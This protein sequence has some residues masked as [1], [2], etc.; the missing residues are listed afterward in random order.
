MVLARKASV[1]LLA[2]LAALASAGCANEL[3]VAAK[4]RQAEA[5]APRIAIAR[6]GGTELAHGGSL[7]FGPVSVGGS[8]ELV[9]EVRNDGETTLVLPSGAISIAGGSGA[10]AAEDF[11]GLSLA[12]GKSGSFGLRFSPAAAGSYSATLTIA[13]NDGRVPAFA[14]GLT[15][16]GSATAKALT[17]FGIL[18][19][20]IL[21][22]IDEAAK[23][24]SLSLPPATV[25]SAL[26]PTFETTGARVLVG[27][28]VQTSGA[29]VQNFS[30]PVT[31]RV[32]AQDGST[33]DYVVTA[34]NTSI[35]PILGTVTLSS[36]T[37]NSAAG[38]SNVASSGDGEAEVAEC[39]LCWS[40]TA[41][42]TTANSKVVS[43]SK[44]GGF[45]DTVL[46]GLSAG[47]LYYVRAY[48]IND[49]GLTGYGAQSSFMTLPTQPTGISVS[50][51]GYAAGADRLTVSWSAVTGAS[52]Y[53][54]YASKNSTAPTAVT[55][56]TTGGVDV[57][58]TT[59]TLTG[60]ETYAL[61][62]V[63]VRAKNSSGAGAWS[64]FVSRQVGIPVTSI[65][66]EFNRPSMDVPIDGEINVTVKPTPADATE[67][68]V[69]WTQGGTHT[70]FNLID[71]RSSALVRMN[72][73]TY[74]GTYAEMTLR[75]TSKYG[76]GISSSSYTIKTTVPRSDLRA[77]YLFT[78]GSLSDTSGASAGAATITSASAIADRGGAYT[79]AVNTAVDAM[80]LGVNGD[81]WAYSRF[82]VSLWLK[83]GELPVA[84]AYPPIIGQ[85]ASANQGFQWDLHLDPD[86]KLHAYAGT[87]RDNVNHA[88]I[89]TAS[90]VLTSTWRHVAY[91]QNG[92]SVSL[93]V[94]GALVGSALHKSSS[95][96]TDST[97]LQIG[98]VKNPNV[99]PPFYGLYWTGPGTAFA[100]DD[101]RIYGKALS[102]T[103]V[104]SLSR[105]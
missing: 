85:Q 33:A 17:S 80:K 41:N 47:T 70:S 100:F 66:L 36:V 57:T 9:L 53:D 20:P 5:V 18:Q 59:C 27:G 60:L 67:R 12:K 55:T 101:V 39:G 95:S 26:V 54:V 99:S 75:A 65:T 19:P 68:E 76:T 88:D 11:P 24:V 71:Y 21:G 79:K 84:G 102:A 1:R 2:A 25:L 6:Q 58:G 15:G 43:S 3:L 14:L 42:P 56:P 97:P 104:R 103:E 28:A 72:N 4:E 51:V 96:F 23:T 64:S 37:T 105:H 86:G 73:P 40:T 46:T 83:A 13:S 48:A 35:A 52:S 31:Y 7:D 30:T 69:T 62:Y 16:S 29:S 87:W 10:F 93:Y 22:S 90:S 49:A 94:D 81:T 91:V 82:S 32:E 61:Y 63:W 8:R 74:D 89:A 98:F 44:S 92:T 45:S 50:P 34:T 77:E 38:S 78:G